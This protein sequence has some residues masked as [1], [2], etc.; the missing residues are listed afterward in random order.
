MSEFRKG[1]RVR[2]RKAVLTEFRD[3]LGT[4]LEVSEGAEVHVVLDRLE[5]G[6]EA[7]VV[8]FFPGQLLREATREP[9]VWADDASP[10]TGAQVKALLDENEEFRKM[11]SDRPSEAKTGCTATH[12]ETGE[13]CLYDA[14]SGRTATDHEDHVGDRHSWRNESHVP[15]TDYAQAASD[16]AS[17]SD[18][19]DPDEPADRGF[20]CVHEAERDEARD[21]VAYLRNQRDGVNATSA[22]DGDWDTCWCDDCEKRRLLKAS[23]KAFTNHEIFSLSLDAVKA[24]IARPARQ[25]RSN[26]Q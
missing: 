14:A 1:D 25:K 19:T 6:V 22:C 24:Y 8:W 9:V 21:A 26:G 20:V 13:R 5:S 11:V 4:V 7:E 18:G 10:F 15:S 2:T 23:G 17:C 3:R 16:L 12:P